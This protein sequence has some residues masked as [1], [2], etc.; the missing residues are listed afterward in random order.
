[1]TYRKLAAE[2]TIVALSGG[3]E[4]R[5]DDVDGML[6]SVVQSAQPELQP[7]QPKPGQLCKNLFGAVVAPIA[8]AIFARYMY[9][10]AEG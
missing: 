5:L 4:A 8:A 9:V 10:E 6:Q 2:T 1:M 7:V 3:L